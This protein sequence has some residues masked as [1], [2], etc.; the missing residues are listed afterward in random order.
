MDPK[1]LEILKKSKAVEQKTNSVYGKSG[2]PNTH[3]GSKIG[4]TGGLMEQVSSMDG[5]Q[6]VSA[7]EAGVNG[8]MENSAPPTERVDSSNPQY[9]DRVKNS[10][11]PPA[12]AEAMLKNP[13][14]QGSASGVDIFEEDVRELNSDYGKI[15]VEDEDPNVY[16]DGDEYDFMTEQ[17]H[18][19]K[20]R[21][22]SSGGGMTG[23]SE[24]QVKKMIAEEISKVLPKVVEKYFDNKVI[25]ENT[26]LMKVLL[27]ES[28]NK[29]IT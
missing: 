1:L 19:P 12:V 21:R 11:L 5:T 28:R 3:G 13:I 14:P 10:K 8:T 6:L 22:Q 7:E 23:V 20:P 26:R 25:K 9:K 24:A 16:S 18:T 17:R 27:K 2:G 29:K 15:K 4:S